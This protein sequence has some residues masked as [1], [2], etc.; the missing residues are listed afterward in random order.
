MPIDII[1]TELTRFNWLATGTVW[2]RDPALYDQV[3]RAAAQMPWHSIVNDPAGAAGRAHGLDYLS[4]G[5]IA[6]TGASERTLWL[7][8]AKS[9]RTKPVPFTLTGIREITAEGTR[10]LLVLTDDRDRTPIALMERHLIAPDTGT[11]CAD[12]HD[13]CPG[14][15]ADG[16]FCPCKCGCRWPERLTVYQHLAEGDEAFDPAWRWPFT[17]TGPSEEAEH[18]TLS[19]DVHGR[20]EPAPDLLCREP[21]ELVVVYNTWRPGRAASTP[22][23]TPHRKD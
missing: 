18:G 1:A 7:S 19:F 14:K 23:F 17:V 6:A 3:S 9:V 10:S 8:R 16:G 12:A 20:D 5:L 2:D 21:G 15:N 11:A 22:H 13:R 4:S